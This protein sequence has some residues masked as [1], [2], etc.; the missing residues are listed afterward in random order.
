MSSNDDAK[1]NTNE[2]HNRNT[3]TKQKLMCQIALDCLKSWVTFSEASI[4]SFSFL[5]SFWK[6]CVR[7][8][9]IR[10]LSTFWRIDSEMKIEV[11]QK[12]THLKMRIRYNGRERKRNAGRKDK[13]TKNATEKIEDQKIY[14]D[15]NIYIRAYRQS[16]SRE[17][18]K[19]D[20]ENGM[21]K[22]L[23]TLHSLI[24]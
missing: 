2:N 14:Q 19:Y 3:G 5:I 20:C 21:K 7:V 17:N 4:F 8:A 9:N 15:L 13:K 1:I 11:W 6:K 12:M 18:K 22:E 23:G 16:S 24:F 10:S